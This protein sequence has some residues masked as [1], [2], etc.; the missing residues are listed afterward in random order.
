MKIGPQGAR[1]IVVGVLAF[2]VDFGV[3]WLAIKVLPLL[4]ANTI[5]FI[6]ANVFNFLLAHGW[7]FGARFER[8]RFVTAYA[9]VLTVSLVGLLVNNAVVWILVGVAGMGLLPGKIIATLAG[10]VW[11]FTARKIW[12]YKSETP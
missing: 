6:V 2:C 9:A 10:L 8:K 12:I 1:Y 3:T 5:G 11:N 7:V 4:A